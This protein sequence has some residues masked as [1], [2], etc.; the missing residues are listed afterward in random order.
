MNTVATGHEAERA[1]IADMA[2]RIVETAAPEKVILFGSR[3]TGAA[4]PDSD[5]D[6]L[7]VESQAFGPDHSRYKELARLWHALR[8]F[9]VSKDILVYSSDEIEQWRGSRNHIIA[10][11]LREGIVIYDRNH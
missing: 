10:H 11:A 6:L 7:I 2:Q 9:P 1:M 4:R 3:A 8:G 5:V